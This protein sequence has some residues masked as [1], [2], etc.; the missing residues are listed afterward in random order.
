MA[1]KQNGSKNPRFLVR[2][3]YILNKILD[4][5]DKI[6]KFAGSILIKIILIIK[7]IL[8]MKKLTQILTF[9]FVLS[10][11]FYACDT[12]KDPEPVVPP[13]V[14]FTAAQVAG[15]WKL[16]AGSSSVANGAISIPDIFDTSASNLAISSADGRAAFC[17]KNSIL[18][19]AAD[20]TFTEAFA[21]TTYTFATQPTQTCAA[22]SVAGTFAI[23][24]PVVTTPVS[25]SV[26]TLTYAGGNPPARSFTVKAVSATTMTVE[27][28]SNAGGVPSVTTGTYTKQ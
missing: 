15:A 6:V 1:E 10:V 26:L 28:S 7:T 20:G 23:P 2:L 19:L 5:L 21:A 13:V 4:Y 12:K 17:T 24:I 22:S 25:P 8:A 16:T 3:T 9:A 27:I 14:G 18:T 11:S